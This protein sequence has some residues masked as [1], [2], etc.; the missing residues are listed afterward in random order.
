VVHG[1]DFIHPTAVILSASI[2]IADYRTAMEKDGVVGETVE[3]H[4]MTAI[5]RWRPPPK[6][7]LK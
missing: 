1:G 5:V 3:V 7:Y 2:D 4:G 6:E